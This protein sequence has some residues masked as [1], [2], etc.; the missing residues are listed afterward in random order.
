MILAKNRSSVSAFTSVGGVSGVNDLLLVTVVSLELAQV[1]LLVGQ[2]LLHSCCLI[3]FTP[4]RPSPSL[5]AGAM[6]RSTPVAV[7]DP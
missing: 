2:Q 4:C 5:M 1:P 7:V 3:R 6:G